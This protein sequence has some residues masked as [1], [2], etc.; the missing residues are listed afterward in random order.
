LRKYS[1]D[2]SEKFL[3]FSSKDELYVAETV[4]SKIIFQLQDHPICQDISC[5]V[6]NPIHYHIIFIG[7]SNG[8]LCLFDLSKFDIFW[9]KTFESC[10][11]EG[12][13]SSDGMNLFV[14]DSLGQ[15]Y[16]F[17]FVEHHLDFKKEF[18]KIELSNLFL[19]V[20]VLSSPYLRNVAIELDII[21][22]LSNTKISQNPVNNQ[23]PPLII[24]PPDHIP[25]SFDIPLNPN[26]TNLFSNQTPEIEEKKQDYEFLS[27]DSDS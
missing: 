11:L 15:I 27:S 8:V 10:F 12:V 14:S 20:K 3:V 7:N 1:F 19:P 24:V 2:H 4:S 5:I 13:W 17:S 22:R 25:V 9:C 21:T 26:G 16:F 6:G 18:D 23:N